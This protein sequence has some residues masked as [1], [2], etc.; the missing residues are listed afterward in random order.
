MQV[1]GE[2]EKENVSVLNTF[3]FAAIE[4]MDPSLCKT[5]Y[6]ATL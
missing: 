1:K 2:E 6:K 3:D 5:L 4:D